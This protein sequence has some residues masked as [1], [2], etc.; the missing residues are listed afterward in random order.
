MDE[1]FF[2]RMPS[3]LTAVLDLVEGCVPRARAIQ[4]FA[5]GR[6]E[7]GD[8]EERPRRLSSCDDVGRTDRSKSSSATFA[9]LCYSDTDLVAHTLARRIATYRVAGWESTHQKRND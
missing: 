4:G 5:A 8:P 3:A 7:P 1:S 6:I 9:L 2:G